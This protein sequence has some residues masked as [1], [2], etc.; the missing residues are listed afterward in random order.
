M[1]GNVNYFISASSQ[2][3]RSEISLFRHERETSDDCWIVSA[4][5]GVSVLY[6][7]VGRDDSI[8]VTD[9]LGCAMDRFLKESAVEIHAIPVIA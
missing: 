7:I 8:A 2:A 5:P 3:Y 9:D 6:E 4:R 1:K